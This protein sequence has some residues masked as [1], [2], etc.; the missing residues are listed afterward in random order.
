MNTL[1]KYGKK[2]SNQDVENFKNENQNTDEDVVREIEKEN[3]DIIKYR[4][5][6]FIEKIKLKALE[7]YGNWGKHW[8]SLQYDNYCDNNYQPY[9]WK[10]SEPQEKKTSN[11]DS[12]ID[13][14]KALIKENDEL[15]TEKKKIE[16]DLNSEIIKMKK[17][18]I[19]L[20]EKLKF[21]DSDID[22]YKKYKEID[23]YDEENWCD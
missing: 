3:D 11:N 1:L 16:R 13:T 7:S 5:E 10:R 21:I 19:D 4:D 2:S 15:K 6:D 17:I 20:Q 23:P 12:L 9:C 22:R 14:I 8:Y 18:I